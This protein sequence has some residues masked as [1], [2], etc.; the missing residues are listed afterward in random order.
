[1][2]SVGIRYRFEACP[3]LVLTIE[4]A[5]IPV[6]ASKGADI[7]CTLRVPIATM[8]VTGRSGDVG[9]PLSSAETASSAV[10]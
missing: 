10:A 1:M 2:T 4:A 3:L 6:D 9:A 7:K 8:R 5:I